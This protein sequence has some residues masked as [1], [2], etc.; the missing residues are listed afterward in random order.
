[1]ANYCVIGDCLLSLSLCR[2]GVEKENQLYVTVCFI[3]LMKRSICFGHFCAHH[4][5]L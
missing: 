2:G 5:E 4:Q 3:A 1:M